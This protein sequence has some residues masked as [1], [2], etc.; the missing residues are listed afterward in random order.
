[1]TS[2]CPK[3]EVQSCH[4]YLQALR[5]VASTA[6]QSPVASQPLLQA[7]SSSFVPSVHHLSSHLRILTHVVSLAEYLVVSSFFHLFICLLPFYL[8][9]SA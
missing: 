4:L 1:M 6:T 7:A 2:E 8:S 5:A 3:E 9:I